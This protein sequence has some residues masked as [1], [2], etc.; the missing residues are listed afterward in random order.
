MA[1][2]AAFGSPFFPGGSPDPERRADVIGQDQ[3]SHLH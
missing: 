3:A 2:T 1:T